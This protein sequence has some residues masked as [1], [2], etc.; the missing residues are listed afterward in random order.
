MTGVATQTGGLLCVSS[1]T[2]GSS[3]GHGGNDMAFGSRQL[4]RCAD[5]RRC[6][7][8]RLLDARQRVDL[9]HLCTLLLIPCVNIDDIIAEGDMVVTRYNWRAVDRRRLARWNSL[10]YRW[11]FHRRDKAVFGSEMR[12]TG[13]ADGNTGRQLVRVDKARTGATTG[14]RRHAGSALD[15]CSHA[16]PNASGG[17]PS[18]SGT[19]SLCTICPRFDVPV[20]ND[21]A[22]LGM[23]SRMDLRTCRKRA[24]YMFSVY[25]HLRTPDAFAPLILPDRN[26]GYCLHAPIIGIL[27]I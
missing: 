26:L 16:S 2:C 17:S 9:A 19:T 8:G 12:S 11:R 20:T 21:L 15:R 24:R 14:R 18:T 22:M 1:V 27:H 13:S 6:T 5:L 25:L 4:A 3:S 10:A 23:L 7:L